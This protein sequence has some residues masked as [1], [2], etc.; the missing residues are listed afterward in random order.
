MKLS[1][2]SRSFT[3]VDRS[4]TSSSQL[5]LLPAS[6]C[7]RLSVLFLLFLSRVSV[8]FREFLSTAEIFAVSISCLPRSMINKNLQLRLP[9]VPS[10]SE[11]QSLS[12][13]CRLSRRS[14]N[15]LSFSGRNIQIRRY[16]SLI[17]CNI[18]IGYY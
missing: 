15:F 18:T 2:I 10:Q 1:R 3:I 13:S 6:S 12:S 17:D 7:P 8:Y 11:N 16:I 14:Y 5:S 9:D 4:K